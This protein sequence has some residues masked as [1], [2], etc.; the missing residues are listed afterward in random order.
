MFYVY[1][2]CDKVEAHNSGMRAFKRAEVITRLTGIKCEVRNGETLLF[3]IVR[4]IGRKLQV[5]PG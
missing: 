3:T 1:A 4:A 2:G 5:I